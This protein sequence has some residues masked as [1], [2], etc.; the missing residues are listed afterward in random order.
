MRKDLIKI[1]VALLAIGFIFVLSILTAIIVTEITSIWLVYPLSWIGGILMII[2]I[3]VVVYGIIA[4]PPPSAKAPKIRAREQ[5]IADADP[6]HMLMT[7]LKFG[8]FF[9]V[10]GFL[11]RLLLVHV[12]AKEYAD[13]ETIVSVGDWLLI[14]FVIIGIL[15]ISFGVVEYAIARKKRRK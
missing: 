14:L 13:A 3:P 4:G 6:I 8:I 10:A 1:G 2:G 15:I 12:V 9:I 11:I 5:K 7:D